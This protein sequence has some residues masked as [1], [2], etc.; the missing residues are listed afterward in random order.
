[1]FRGVWL[2]ADQ[3]VRDR[4]FGLLKAYV[5]KPDE[6]YLAEAS[7]LG[8]ELVLAG[9]LEEDVLEIHEQ[10]LGCLTRELHAMSMT[11]VIAS[12]SA[13]LMEVCMAYSLSYQE[14]IEERKRAEEGIRRLNEELERRVTERTVEL[15]AVNRELEAFTY[16]VTHDL[17]APLRAMDGFSRALLEDYAHKLD[18]RGKDFLERVREASHRMNEL[19]DA[20]LTLSGVASGGLKRETVDLSELA[21][22]VAAELA[23]SQPE[24]DA[25]FLIAPDA[26]ADGDARLLR[27]VLVNLLGNAWKFTGSRQRAKIEFGLTQADGHRAYFVRDNG[28]GFD[29]AYAGKLFGAFQRL[30]SAG[31]FP[32]DGIGLATVQRIVHRHGGRV[33]A[34]SAPGQGATF[35]LT[36]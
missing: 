10:A 33:W 30:H 8:R 28:A 22:G 29:M 3:S 9:V 2:M 14:Q 19:I 16:S 15:A 25:E 24:R 17:R 34:E 32:G 23:E 11:D 6:R 20:M 1:M 18:P 36:L 21:R 13:P 27:I 31:E 12:V 7:E 4:Y 35:Y 26:L 5:T